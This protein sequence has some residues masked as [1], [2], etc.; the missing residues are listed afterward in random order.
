M[1]LYG[2]EGVRAVQ[3]SDFA[4]HEFKGLW[5][6]V[7]VHG[8]W[9]YIRIS[10]MILYF[11]YKN[12]IFT[13]PQFYFAFVCAFSG[14]TIFD[15]WYITFYNLVFTAMPLIVRAI[16]DQDVY[17][18][19]PLTSDESSIERKGQPVFFKELPLIKRY[20]P[21]L[22]SVGQKNQ[23]FQDKKFLLWCFQ[24]IVHG[25]IVFV[26]QLYVITKDFTSKN[27][28]S[29]DLWLFSISLYTSIILVWFIHF[30]Y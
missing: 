16:M 2:Q 4:L 25:I 14:Q 19:I 18:R 1:G 30:F 21:K 20:Y 9:S 15:D 11:F 24:G 28:Y 26:I 13:I 23:I 10:E 8:K 6:L 3:A 5:K 29:P 7:L 17:Y 27:G 12:M 22:Y